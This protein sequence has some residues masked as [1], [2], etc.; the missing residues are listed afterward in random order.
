MKE[1]IGSVI[2]IVSLLGAGSLALKEAHDAIRK[3]ALEKT[4]QGM[5]SLTRLTAALRAKKPARPHDSR[6][7]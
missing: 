7:K 5:P 6:R 2:F 1:L 3:A 4:A